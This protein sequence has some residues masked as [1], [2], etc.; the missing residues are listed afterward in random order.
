[1]I[2]YA[3]QEPAR[4][5]AARVLY[6]FALFLWFLLVVTLLLSLHAPW[7]E[8]VLTYATA[9]VCVFFGI[10]VHTSCVSIFRPPHVQNILDKAISQIDNAEDEQEQI[11]FRT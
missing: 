5:P 3:L 8:P 2:I 7:A 9:V 1:M 10:T 4:F 11:G 6:S